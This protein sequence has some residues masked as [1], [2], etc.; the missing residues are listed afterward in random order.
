MDG[1]NK[2]AQWEGKM[3]GGDGNFALVRP[4]RP[5]ARWRDHSYI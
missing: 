1:G 3:S 2:M 4:R 5:Q